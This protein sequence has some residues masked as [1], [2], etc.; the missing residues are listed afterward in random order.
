MFATTGTSWSASHRVKETPFRYSSWPVSRATIRAKLLRPHPTRWLA[1]A[2]ICR[3]PPLP[4]GLERIITNAA[5]RLSDA[6]HT[7]SPSARVIGSVTAIEVLLIHDD[8]NSDYKLLSERTRSLLGPWTSDFY[9]ASAVYKTRHK[10]VHTGLEVTDQDIELR[11]VGLALACILRFAE[12]AWSF[13]HK[14]AVLEYLDWH[15][16][17]DTVREKLDETEGEALNKA[18]HNHFR[19]RREGPPLDW[20]PTPPEMIEMVDEFE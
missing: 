14:Q 13:P 15:T 9:K 16:N 6:V 4:R 11:A 2:L 18:L 1:N 17:A 5:L 12:A 19:H 3:Q 7:F 10:C 20:V 8:Q